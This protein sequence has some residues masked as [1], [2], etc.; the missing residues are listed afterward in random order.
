M[1]PT[2]DQVETER[3]LQD[4]TGL[5]YGTAVETDEVGLLSVKG[6]GIDFLAV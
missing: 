1:A 4:R 6:A 2:L 3:T 5:A